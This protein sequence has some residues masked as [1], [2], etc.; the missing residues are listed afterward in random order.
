MIGHRDNHSMKNRSKMYAIRQAQSDLLENQYDSLANPVQVL[1][2]KEAAPG[3]AINKFS[4]RV[5][6]GTAKQLAMKI[7][8]L[9]SVDLGLKDNEVQSLLPAFQSYYSFRCHYLAMGS[10]MYGKDL[11]GG[12]PPPSYCCVALQVN[13]PMPPIHWCCCIGAGG[14]T[15]PQG[16]HR[17]CCAA[18]CA[19]R[20]ANRQKSM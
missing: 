16:L 20:L 1:P 10:E 14:I 3:D 18:A 13:P 4:M 7:N 5:K 12:S 17:C 11:W 9:A 19:N 6:I 8:I 2:A 15:P